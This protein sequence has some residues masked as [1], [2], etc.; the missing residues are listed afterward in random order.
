MIEEKPYKKILYDLRKRHSIKKAVKPNL[1]SFRILR[2]GKHYKPNFA[3]VL[4]KLPIA[5][6]ISIDNSYF[7]GP[8]KPISNISGNSNFKSFC[9]LIETRFN[10]KDSLIRIKEFG[11]KLAHFILR[12]NQSMEELDYLTRQ[13]VIESNEN[14][15][16][17]NW[18]IKYDLTGIFRE[19]SGLEIEFKQRR[20]MIYFNEPLENLSQVE[21]LIEIGQMLSERKAL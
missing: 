17:V 4:E 3:W 20:L 15:L 18:L 10:F 1:L 14:L 5:L 12:K 21:R 11:D 13:Y 6:L 9:C 19:Y 7:T 8:P 16:F 2:I